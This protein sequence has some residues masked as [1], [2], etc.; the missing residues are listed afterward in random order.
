M[1]NRLVLRRTVVQVASLLMCSLARA[2]SPL[3]ASPVTLVPAAVHPGDVVRVVIPGVDAV[4]VKVFGKEI[5]GE[6][7]GIDL[8]TKPG[9]YPMAIETPAG[10]TTRVLRVLPKAFPVRR[11]AVAPAYVEPPAEEVERIIRELKLT[12][13]IF[14]TTTPRKWSGGFVVPV[15]APASSNFGSRSYFNGQRRS[16][17]A[18]VDFMAVT[19]TPVH[20]GN[21]GVIALAE[22]LY[23]TGN[24]VI[25]DYGSGL[26][27]LFAH[28]SAFS[29]KSG[30]SVSPD[31]EVG[32]VGAT[33]RVTGPHLHWSVRLQGARVDPLSLV[34]ATK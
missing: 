34:S 10:I 23:F 8:D 19:G 11:L 7:I 13:S 30:D 27:S 32:L 5:A 3:P 24:T 28:L 2:Q 12:E 29:V 1:M 14:H 31:T 25:V 20:A 21:F 33:G 6:L 9:S 18:G 16:P 15:D 22:P 26:Y 4:S 17:H